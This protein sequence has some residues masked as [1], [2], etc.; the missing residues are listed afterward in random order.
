MSLFCPP[1]SFLN[2]VFNNCGGSY[3]P[4]AKY[5]DVGFNGTIRHSNI[6][7]PITVFHIVFC[8]HYKSVWTLFVLE[9]WKVFFDWS[10]KCN[11][12]TMVS[13]LLDVQNNICKFLGMLFGLTNCEWHWSN[14]T[15]RKV[16]WRIV[17]LFTNIWPTKNW[18]Q[19][20]FFNVLLHF[21][22]FLSDILITLLKVKFFFY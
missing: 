15:T 19:W 13:I 22:F 17:I 21:F 20:S 1:W 6:C 12:A 14:S 16:L 8:Y 11:L 10:S 7:K 4:N 3:K 18:F 5:L 9:T 2:H